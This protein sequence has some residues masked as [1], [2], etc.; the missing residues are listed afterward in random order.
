MSAREAGP[1]A[2]DEREPVRERGR[3]RGRGRDDPGSLE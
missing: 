2:V 3:D 1:R